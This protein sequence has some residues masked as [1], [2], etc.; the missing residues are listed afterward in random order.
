MITSRGCEE[1]AI[2]PWHRTLEL[3]CDP[4]EHRFLPESCAEHHPDRKS[5]A[6]EVQRQRH[7]RQARRVIDRI[8][9]IKLREAGQEL[10]DIGRARI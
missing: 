7:R 9:A 2:G 3:S 4:K 1:V 6:G 8:E 5:A 10:P